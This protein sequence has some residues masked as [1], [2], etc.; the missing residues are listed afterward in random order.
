[1]VNF[2]RV[3]APTVQFTRGKWRIKKGKTIRDTSAE[4]SCPYCGNVGSLEEHKIDTDGTV[5]PRAGCAK[6]GCKFR[7]DI[8]LLD[9]DAFERV[10]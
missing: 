9:W 5:S 10:L 8:R 6:E 3:F 2:E 7:D 1:M 4:I